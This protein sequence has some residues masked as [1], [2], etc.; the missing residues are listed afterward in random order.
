MR[1]RAVM[2]GSVLASGIAATAC[3]IAMSHW[4]VARGLD[5]WLLALTAAM[6]GVLLAVASVQWLTARW[7]SA[8]T[9]FA[10]D[11]ARGRLEAAAPSSRLRELDVLGQHIA[12]LGGALAEASERLR[13]Q[14][15]QDSL[16]GLPN[17]T[18][19]VARA[20]ELL[21]LQRLPGSLALLFIDLDRF[22]LV[23]ETTGHAV[24]D[25]LLQAVAAR[26]QAVASSDILLARLG[27]DEFT[28]LI[29]GPL[30]KKQAVDLAARIVEGLGGPFELGGQEIFVTAS[31]GISCNEEGEQTVTELMRKADVALYRAKGE[32]RGRF[33]TFDA[34][35]DAISVEELRLG[36][37]LRAAVEREELT[38]RYQ[39]EVDLRS[40]RLVGIEA[41]VRWNHPQRGVLSP[42][43]FMAMAEE[44]GEIQHIGSW[45]L[46]RA[47]RQAVALG[48]TGV[49]GQELTVAV[50]L[51]PSEFKE[52]GLASEVAHILDRSGL[53]ARR[54]KLEI[55]ESVLIEDIQ[56]ATHTMQ[57]LNDLGVRLA[58]DDFGTGYSSLGYLQL[59]PVDTL[60]IDQSFVK[61]IGTSRRSDAILRAII[62]LGRALDLHVVA[63]GIESNEQFEFLRTAECAA[64]Q[65]FLFSEPLSGQEVAKVLQRMEA[66]RV[67][68]RMRL[69]RRGA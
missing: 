8:A 26:L 44:T 12:T 55:T 62:D 33:A 3:G 37:D 6:S 29:H 66:E 23:N 46:E 56:R 39:P 18:H 2:G 47:C 42:A 51:S 48:Q 14:A 11:T 40:G 68:P 61:L 13:R 67:S 43:V 27:G 53:P 45:V 63:E 1:L 7:L 10:A 60:K 54:L 59:L 30:A 52:P 19:F 50:N 20:K 17:R 9:T 25:S 69:L 65:G 41:L 31:I 24:G 16:T 4:G 15:S 57:A 35:T 22:K 21:A 34:A 64:G 49:T 58:I 38:L 36:S 5:L 28:A 32:A